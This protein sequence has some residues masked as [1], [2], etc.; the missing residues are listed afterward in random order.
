MR[1]NCVDCRA[2]NL[3]QQQQQPNRD[4]RDG[5]NA[6]WCWN[7]SCVIEPR[8]N[9]EPS[10]RNRWND[11][12]PQRTKWQNGRCVSGQ[13]EDI[14]CAER[15][16][17]LRQIFFNYK[18]CTQRNCRL[19]SPLLRGNSFAQRTRAMPVHRIRK[20]TQCGQRTQSNCRP[21]SM[22]LPCFRMCTYPSPPLSA[23][24]RSFEFAHI[25]IEIDVELIEVDYMLW[26]SKSKR[27][28]HIRNGA[29]I[30]SQCVQR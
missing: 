19:R 22:P 18:F 28:K 23:L 24:C 16:E 13:K 6:A 7:R 25:W 9:G 29:A 21:L 20:H 3:Q 12:G 14:H 5:E 4:S 11:S 1:K 10:E 8:A 2:L 26:R 17:E 30:V 15:P 27:D